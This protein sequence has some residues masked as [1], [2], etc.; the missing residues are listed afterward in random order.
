MHIFRQ[1]H[2]GCLPELAREHEVAWEM[3]LLF[4]WAEGHL[5]ALS[6]QHIVG[7]EN[8]HVDFLSRHLLDPGAWELSLRAFQKI[9]NHWGRLAVDLMATASNAKATFFYSCCKEP[10]SQGPDTL[11]QH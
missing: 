5:L 6:A 11:V 4:P 8:V 1:C 3:A 7:V 2:H 10:S 9:V